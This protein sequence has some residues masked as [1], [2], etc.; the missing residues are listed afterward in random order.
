ME[1]GIENVCRIWNS[2]K[3]ERLEKSTASAIASRFFACGFFVKEKWFLLSI[4][5][6]L[7]LILVIEMNSNEP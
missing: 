7:A 5:Q 4:D 2:I 3:K 6:C 1:H